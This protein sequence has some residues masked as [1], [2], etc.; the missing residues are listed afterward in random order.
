MLSRTFAHQ[1]NMMAVRK[2][3]T[4]SD[5]TAAPADPILGLNE[6]FKKETN[7]RKVLLNMGAFRCD[8]G[9]PYILEC[10]KKAEQLI[11]E[12]NMDHEYAGI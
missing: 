6:A 7:P 1:K 3:G 9:K 8:K 2:Y 11:L 5:I 4:W 10:V 12:K